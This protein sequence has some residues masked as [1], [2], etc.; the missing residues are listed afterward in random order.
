MRRPGYE[1]K[2]KNTENSI[3]AQSLIA[4]NILFLVAGL[5][6]ATRVPFKEEVSIMKILW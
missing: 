5:E 2:V 3:L 4:N 6:E 1:Y